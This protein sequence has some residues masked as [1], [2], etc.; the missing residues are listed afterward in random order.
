MSFKM[1]TFVVMSFS[2]LWISRHLAGIL[3]LLNRWYSGV[4]KLAVLFQSFE[5]ALLKTFS[6]VL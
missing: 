1:G 4:G 2:F 3:S 6:V 5:R